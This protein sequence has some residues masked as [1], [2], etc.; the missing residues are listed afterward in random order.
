MTS[1]VNQL[2]VDLA[3]KQHN[4]RL[5]AVERSDGSSPWIYVGTY[6]G[7]ANTT[8]ES[9]PFENGW[10][11]VFSGQA[12]VSFKRFSNWTHI[13]GAFTGGSDGTVVFTLPPEYAP[14]YP[15]A[16]TGSLTDGSGVWTCII[17]TDGSVTYVTQGA[18]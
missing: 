14:L 16:I 4:A 18:I 12:P 17:G 11:N 13:R 6:P 15:Q 9:P 10:G 2:S 1:S 7:D 5:T 3:L 8:P